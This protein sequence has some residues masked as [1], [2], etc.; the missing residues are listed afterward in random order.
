MN[1]EKAIPR[2]RFLAMSIALDGLVAYGELRP[3]F[4]HSRTTNFLKEEPDG[5]DS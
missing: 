3:L 5:S 1:I 4:A 2:R